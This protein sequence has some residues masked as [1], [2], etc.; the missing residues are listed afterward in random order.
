MKK[1]E[2]YNII[3]SI[4]GIRKIP[5]V[6]Y[7]LNHN[8]EKVCSN[9]ENLS[10]KFNNDI[11]KSVYDSTLENKINWKYPRYSFK[12]MHSGRY[13]VWG[14]SED[15]NIRYDL[16]PNWNNDFYFKLTIEVDKPHNEIDI[17]EN[18]KEL[19]KLYK[20][21]KINCDKSYYAQQKTDTEK[22]FEIINK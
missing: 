16:Y 8:E 21:I 11:I 4:L 10:F 9:E 7:D 14:L 2:I 3:Y 12:Q 5:C 17:L 19:K 18:Q 1:L 22:V 6:S 15:K 20:L 13:Q